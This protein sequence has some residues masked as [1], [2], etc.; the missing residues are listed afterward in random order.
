M[1]ALQ[2]FKALH[3]SIALLC[4]AIIGLYIYENKVVK[5]DDYADIYAVIPASSEFEGDEPIGFFLFADNLIRESLSVRQ[6]LMCDYADDNGFGVVSSQI[7]SI[8]LL[9]KD[10]VL[11]TEG[12]RIDDFG[13]NQSSVSTELRK[14]IGQ[15]DVAD[16]VRYESIP[17]ETAQCFAKF[18]F[19]KYTPNFNIEKSFD[20]T[21]FPFDYIWYYTPPQ[22]S[23][24]EVD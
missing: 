12:H 13:G 15:G 6:I 2:I 18:R 16:F 7:T 14:L 20:T 21:S 22:I 4:L 9:A 19:T 3:T 23:L 8:D 5:F 11:A 10:Q 1:K 24:K 17:K